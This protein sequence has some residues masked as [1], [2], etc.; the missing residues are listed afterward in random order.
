MNI[1]APR[2]VRHSAAVYRRIEVLNQHVL[3]G[4]YQPIW[5]YSTI[6]TTGSSTVAAINT[7]TTSSTTTAT[8]TTSTTITALG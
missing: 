3:N 5:Y 7:T 8:T 6:T 4:C 1:E 2:V